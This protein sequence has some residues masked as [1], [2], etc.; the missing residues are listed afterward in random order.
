MASILDQYEQAS[1]RTVVSGA[2]PS[3]MPEP[4]PK[5]NYF[6]PVG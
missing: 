2:A 5:L 6:K 4:V 1:S 3:P